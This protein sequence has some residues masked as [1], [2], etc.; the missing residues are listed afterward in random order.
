LIKDLKVLQILLASCTLV[1]TLSLSSSS[2]V[3]EE[4]QTWYFYWITVLVFFTFDN[5]R[6]HTSKKSLKM[7]ILLILSMVSHR[8]LRTLNSTGD[9]YAYLP[10][11]SGWLQDQDSNIGMT[12]I[13]IFG[14]F[15]ILS[16]N[17]YLNMILLLFY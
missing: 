13:L 1:Y 14:I 4:H 8:V 10:D 16:F 2:F 12:V 11:I 6:K 17:K 3:E 5:L 15:I 7:L 9:K